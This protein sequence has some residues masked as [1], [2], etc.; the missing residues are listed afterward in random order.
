M[1]TKGGNLDG[2]RLAVS[3]DISNLNL[4]LNDLLD[5]PVCRFV[6]VNGDYVTAGFLT[7]LLFQVF[8]GAF[9]GLSVHQI[10]SSMQYS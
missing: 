4:V 5:P 2:R 7:A 6:K 9:C 1:W 8:K 10:S 3:L